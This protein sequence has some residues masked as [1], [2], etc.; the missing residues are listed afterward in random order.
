MES[1]RWVERQ[2]SA[3]LPVPYFHVVFT[4]PKV[5][6]DLALYNK[7][8]LY[9]LLLR[10]SAEVVKTIGADKKFFGGEMGLLS[11]LHTW[12]QTL[13]HHPHVHMVVPGGVLHEDGSWTSC[14][15][16]YL[17][18]CAVLAK[19]FRRRFLEELEQ[20]REQDALRFQGRVSALSQRKHWDAMMKKVRKTNWVV[21]AKAPFGGPGQVLKYLARYTHRVAISNRRLIKF[22]GQHVTFRHRVPGEAVEQ[23][24]TTL[25]LAAFIERFCLHILPQGFCRIRS[26]GFLAPG[27]RKEKLRQIRK[28][29]YTKGV[30]KSASA[31]PEREAACCPSCGVGKLRQVAELKPRRFAEYWLARRRP[32]LATTGP[33]VMAGLA[34]L[35]LARAACPS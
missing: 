7:E 34:V 25:P 15:P 6:G 23:T 31:T 17:L 16:N 8:L 3:L 29:L 33:P 18:P 4:L 35:P 26:Y 1:R 12:S 13:E 30:M 32:S 24:E 14:K 22:D 11:V 28:S 27:R 21:Y 20:L 2:E 9:G 19:L 5:L 10:V